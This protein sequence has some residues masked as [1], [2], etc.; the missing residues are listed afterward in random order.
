MSY[1]VSS[2]NFF[3]TCI[4]LFLHSHLFAINVSI[5]QITNDEISYHL[6][7]KRINKKC[8]ITIHSQHPSIN[9]AWSNNLVDIVVQQER[10]IEERVMIVVE[11]G[12]PNQRVGGYKKWREYEGGRPKGKLTMYRFSVLESPSLFCLWRY[13]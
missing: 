8:D 1:F 4:K 10:N 3:I 7:N 2:N 5:V 12:S 6:K 11:V 9:P 13:L